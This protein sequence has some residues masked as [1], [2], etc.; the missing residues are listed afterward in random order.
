MN[1]FAR[2]RRGLFVFFFSIL[3][4]VLI[5]LATKIIFVYDSFSENL[6]SHS[7]HF[8]HNIELPSAV[9]QV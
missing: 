6:N 5:F 8:F 2:I 3:S 9:M 4:K 1:Q 7:C